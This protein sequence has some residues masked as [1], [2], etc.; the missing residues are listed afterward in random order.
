[1]PQ[2][3]GVDVGSQS[4]KAVCLDD[5]GTVVRAASAPLSMLHRHNGWAEQRPL[6]WVAQLGA[7]VGEITAPGDLD[8][9]MIALACQVDGVVPVDHRLRPLRDALIW[10]DRRAEL[11]TDAFV[12]Q[13]SLVE[14]F[15]QTG[16][17][18]D[19]SHCAPKM[20]W[21]REH[22]P[23]TWAA[24]RYLLPVTAYLVGWL[25]GT[26]AQDPANASSTMLYDLSSGDYSDSLCALA[27]VPREFL[28]PI[29][30]AAEVCGTVNRDAALLLG[31]SEECEVLVGTGDEHA[32]SIAAGACKEGI[33][34]DVTGTAEPVTTAASGLHL[35]P[36]RLVETHAH[37]VDGLYLVENPG[38]VSGG[39]TLWLADNILGVKQ[40][41]VFEL[42]ANAP[43]G[44]DGVTFVP[45]LTGS[46]TPRWNAGLRAAFNG[47]SM[48]HTRS[49]L[50]RAVLEGCAFALRDIVERISDLGLGGDEVRIVGGGGRS[51]LWNQIKADVLGRPVRR[52]LSPDG[53]ALGVASLAAVSAGFFPSLEAATDIVIELGKSQIEPDAK[54]HAR[55]E[56]AYHDYRRLFDGIEGASR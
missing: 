27:G 55:Y 25:T 38:F 44:S 32:A 45:A 52:V 28:P 19:A 2:V 4:V 23:D 29:A 24:T 48:N 51:Q 31:L 35:D 12:R 34:C 1:M 6:D 13:T 50:A 11:Q 54:R 7:V 47:L 10:L 9:R 39:S 5:S 16:L 26:V 46:M 33:I 18:A 21:I 56:S 14:I 36:D 41:A 17:N 30:K 8:V 3:I 40:G 49:N 43:V 15:T 37:A 53:T 22:D 42:A 20:M